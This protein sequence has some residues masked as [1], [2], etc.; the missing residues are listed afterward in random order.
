MVTNKIKI[1]KNVLTWVCKIFL[2]V[3][4]VLFLFAGFLWSFMP[5]E[6]LA[7]YSI[8]ISDGL[9]MN[10]IK[11]SMGAPLFAGS[12]FLLLF[13]FKGNQWFLP[14]FIFVAAHFLVRT[15]SLFVDGS[16]PEVIFSMG[17]EVVVLLA[18]YGLYKLR[19]SE[20]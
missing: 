11:T 12:I 13:V 8:T 18:L 20:V 7:T 4:G 3:A 6:N 15:I 1:M 16:Y 14:I 19:Q 10:M 9:G 5:D 2:I 17:L